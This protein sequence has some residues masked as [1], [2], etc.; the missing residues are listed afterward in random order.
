MESLGIH[1]PPVGTLSN[2]STAPV[3]DSLWGCYFHVEKDTSLCSR[4]VC[5]MFSLVMTCHFRHLKESMDLV[6]PISP[7]FKKIMNL[8][9]LPSSLRAEGCSCDYWIYLPQFSISAEARIASHKRLQNYHYVR[10]FVV[11]N[12]YFL[13]FKSVIGFQITGSVLNFVPRKLGIVSFS[14]HN[15]WVKTED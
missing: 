9:Y 5:F 10:L 13:K 14:V 11:G 1:L 4:S 15:F 2:H 12:Y 6:E 3:W 8:C 7:L